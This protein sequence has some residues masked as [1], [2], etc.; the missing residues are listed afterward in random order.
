M[1]LN[2]VNESARLIIQQVFSL[3]VWAR[4]GATTVAGHLVYKGL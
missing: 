2:N 3:Y 4:L 1:R